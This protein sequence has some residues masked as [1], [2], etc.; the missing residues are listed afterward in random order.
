MDKYYEELAISQRYDFEK[1][2][3]F[4]LYWFEETDTSNA[5]TFRQ[6]VDRLKTWI[7]NRVAWI[8]ENVNTLVP[9]ECTIT[10]LV[11]GKTYSTQKIYSGKMISAL[12]KEPKKKGYVFVGWYGE[13][14]GEEIQVT[15]GYWISG[16]LTLR[17]RWIPEKKVKKVQKLYFQT[18]N[19]YV[20]LY[21][22]GYFMNYTVMPL[23]AT[24]QDVSWSSSNEKIA[25]V[26]ASGYVSFQSTGTV[27]IT[28]TCRNG[29]S[30][31]CRLHIVDDEELM[32]PYTVTLNKSSLKLEAGK[33][34]KLTPKLETPDSCTGAFQWYSSNPEVADIT[35]AGVVLANKAGTATII[36]Y[37]TL[38]GS[39][40]NCT[41]TVEKPVKKGDRF[42]VSGLK[43]QVTKTG[44]KGTVACVGR[45]KS[46]LKKVKIPATVKI[47][48]KRYKVTAV[49]KSAFKGTNIT[50]VSLG[51]NIRTIGEGAFRGCKGITGITIPKNVTQIKKNAF[52]GCKKLSVIT[53]RTTKLS[54]IGS[55]AWKGIRDSAR[56]NVPS[57]KLKAYKKL[58]KSSTGYKKKTMKI[59]TI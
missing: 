6:E 59:K 48:G 42:T 45:A 50:S 13:E 20:S 25:T 3:A 47:K 36:V 26:D 58:L 54:G 17:A 30:A 51:S 4:E 12:P 57:K 41:V 5:L 2:G 21:E 37:S 39:F 11:S 28:G 24:V 43:Y 23:D 33:W 40:A 27:K 29:V 53:V 44:I 16:S 31:S 49:G 55:G 35:D 38:A 46:S 1:W 52:Y 15:E 14:Y 7:K 8:D 56:F 22:E 18:N 32:Y 9:M 19:V 34:A 10:Y